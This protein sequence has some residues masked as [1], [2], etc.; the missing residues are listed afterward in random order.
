MS[1]ELLGNFSQFN[2]GSRGNSPLCPMS[3]GRSPQR[4]HSNKTLNLLRFSSTHPLSCDHGG[5]SK[6]NEDARIFFSFKSIWLPDGELARG[7]L[8]GGGGLRRRASASIKQRQQLHARV[9]H[10]SGA[11]ANDQEEIISWEDVA[12]NIEDLSDSWFTVKIGRKVY[13]ERKSLARI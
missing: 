5:R 4:A 10:L 11:I 9:R 6:G 2:A 7:H 12:R 8:S 3:D 13:D 1:Y